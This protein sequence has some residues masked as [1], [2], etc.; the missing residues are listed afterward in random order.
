MRE[1]VKADEPF[2]RED[3]TVGEALERFRAEDQPYKV[4]LIEDLVARPGRRDGLPLHQRRLHRPLPRPARARRPSAS[5]RSSC[6]RV[7]GAYWRGDA[8]PASSS[9]ASTARRS[10]PRTTSRRTSSASSRPAPATTAS[11]AA[12]SA[13]SPSP[14]SRPARRSGCPTARACSTSSS[15]CRARWAAARGYT[16][17]KT[18]QLYDARAVEDLGPLGQVPR[19]HVRHASPRTARWRSSR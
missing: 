9:R 15:R 3:V 12:S 1:H 5:R 11:S 2:V 8:E 17:V 6:S 14:R 4:E 7:A 10:S 13:C 18:P 16:E 19:A